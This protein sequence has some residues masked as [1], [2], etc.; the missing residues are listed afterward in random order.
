MSDVRKKCVLC[1][2]RRIVS[3]WETC[4]FILLC[5]ACTNGLNSAYLLYRI[6]ENNDNAMNKNGAMNNFLNSQTLI[7]YLLK[8]HVEYCNGNWFKEYMR[9]IKKV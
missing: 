8:Y 6:S 9:T 2:K 7:E 5:N 4:A 1:F 3:I